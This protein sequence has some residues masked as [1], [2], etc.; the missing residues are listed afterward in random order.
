MRHKKYLL[1]WKIFICFWLGCILF[2]YL[3]NK[4]YFIFMMSFSTPITVF[5]YNLISLHNDVFWF[6]LII[7][8][9]VY[10]SLYKILKEFGWNSFNKQKGFLKIFNR[11]SMIWDYFVDIAQI[12]MTFLKL[13]LKN[14]FK[15]IEI[16]I[17]TYFHL[18]LNKNFL[19]NSIKN[20]Y[21]LLFGTE[22]FK[23]RQFPKLIF[24]W[25]FDKL[26]QLT[27][28]R[29]FF[30]KF[31]SK[32]NHA[33]FLYDSNKKLLHI[34]QFKHSLF[35]EYAFAIFPTII[36]GWILIPSFY[37]LY[38]LDDDSY[39]LFTIKVIG[40][41]WYWSYEFD[42]FINNNYVSY[43]FDSVLVQESDLN[44]GEKRLLTVDN[45]L[46]IPTAA[47]IR[48]LITSSDVL[49]SWSIPEFGLK[50]DA[51]P[52]RLNEFITMICKPGFYYGQCSELCGVAHGFMPIVVETVNS[53]I[54]EQYI[55]GKNINQ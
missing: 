39:P 34:L 18:K 14:Y 6:I 10:W 52:G 36:I 12:W 19:L 32:T 7:L 50:V 17:I 47:N 37:L 54:W 27:I 28:E 35:L 55:L 45:N 29:F 8:T 16:L 15:L 31:Y 51:I 33:K 23:G 4:A 20:F 38:S 43:N 11:Y 46:I 42:N 1:R 53:N 2:T 44:K 21:L 40:H 48:F 41:Q 22:F 5:N 26:E 25:D 49:H 30:Y 24:N 13:W 3:H 9:L